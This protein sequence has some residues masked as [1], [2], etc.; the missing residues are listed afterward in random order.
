M[1]HRSLDPDLTVD[2]GFRDR[3]ERF[4][5]SC[6]DALDL[7]RNG[8]VLAH[9]AFRSLADSGHSLHA[10]VDAMAAAMAGGTLLMPTMSWRTVNTANPVFDESTT[11]SITG[12]L[13]EL[14][15]LRHATARSLHPTH[16]VAGAGAA[17]HDLLCGAPRE[18]PCHDSGPW[19]LLAGTD[20]HILLLGV[21]MAS[22]TLIHRAEEMVAPDLYI[23]PTATAETYICRSRSGAE[24]A[25]ATRRHRRLRRNFHIFRDRLE[26]LG[27]VRRYR[28]G[29]IE[30]LAFR[31]DAMLTVA[32][33][34]LRAQPDIILT[35]PTDNPA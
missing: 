15:R 7:P 34:M 30:A 13:T 10:V 19:A 26:A 20:A 33:D 5:D 3:A 18:T 22:C 23:A 16:S 12:A 14:F 2:A 17:A 1:T 28:D 35:T 11:P 8:V 27:G 21:G 24:I 29:A 9:S 32:V 4:V 6:F 31:A 25:V